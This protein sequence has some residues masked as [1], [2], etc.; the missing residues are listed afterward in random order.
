MQ[1]YKYDELDKRGQDYVVQ[2][3]GDDQI[4]QEYIA[5]L[6]DFEEAGTD[7]KDISPATVFDSL[8]WRFNEH[9]EWIA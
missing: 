3:Y 4:V 7:K 6:L 2:R 9:G 1:T 8:G 5:E